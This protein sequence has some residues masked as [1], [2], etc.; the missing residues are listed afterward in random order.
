MSRARAGSLLLVGAGIF[1]IAAIALTIAGQAVGL[2]V[3]G[4]GGIVVIAILSLLAIG[5]AIL[6]V[7]NS[8][9]M[10]RSR[11]LRASLGIFAVGAFMEAASAI[12]SASMNTG[13]LESMPLVILMIG[14]G[15]VMLLGFAA[16]A[17]TYPLA[18]RDLPA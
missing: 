1:T 18:R 13:G 17:I 9:V 15:A 3:H 14:G 11:G 2:G 12:G 6:A 7:A 8:P 4:A 5:S 10:L 16:L